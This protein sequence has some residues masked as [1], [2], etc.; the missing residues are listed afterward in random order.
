MDI[1]REDKTSH[2]FQRHA[3]H[4]RITLAF[5]AALTGTAIALCVGVLLSALAWRLGWSSSYRWWFVLAGPL[6]ASFS[7]LHAHRNRWSDLNVALY[8]DGCL[9]SSEAITTAVGLNAT[10][11]DSPARTV[12]M[13]DAAEALKR[14]DAIRP[15][16]RVLRRHHGMIPIAAL[17]FVWTV[18]LPMRVT[19]APPTSPGTNLVSVADVQG[20]EKVIALDALR[21]PDPAQRERLKRIAQDANALRDRLSQGMER[22]EALSELARLRD[23]VAAE[24]MSIGDGERRAGL[25]VAQGR[26]AQVP[27]LRRAAKALGD[28][29]LTR[30]DDEMQRV[31]GAR[32]QR[33]RD[34][35]RQALEDAAQEAQRAGAPDVARALEDQRRLF[36]SREGRAQVL[37]DFG[38]ALD[39]Q[40]SPEAKKELDALSSG[41]GNADTAKLS[42]ALADALGRLTEQERA[43]LAEKLARQAEGDPNVSPMSKDHLRKLSKQLETDEGKRNLEEQLRQMANAPDQSEESRRQRSLDDAER[44]LGEAERKL[45]GLPIPMLGSEGSSNQ[46]GSGSDESS[47]DQS[48]APQAGSHHDKGHGDHKGSTAPV[49]GTELRARA[50]GKINPAAPMP[51]VVAGRGQAR[52]G[53]TANVRGS[54]VLGEV[55]PGELGGVERSEI[56]QEYREHVGRYFSP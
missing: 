3:R 8:L 18:R 23:A 21:T 33:D 48:G 42:K 44:G 40:L 49:D 26:L 13:R 15:R 19:V 27:A 11:A 43:R 5:R 53:E 16:L 41:V 56:P 22:R 29:D 35:A 12:V 34:A 17:A 37:R 6:G 45:G 4:V 31:A 1:R 2:L 55:G 32:E 39:D 14:V 51:G 24:R 46:R 52:I 36:D 9:R 54:G 47:S 7:L 50:G 20:L 25:E 38:K 30:F 10:G 28:R